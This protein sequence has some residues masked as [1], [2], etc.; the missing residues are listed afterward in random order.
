MKYNI[1]QKLVSIYMN[2]TK[3]DL[4]LSLSHAYQDLKLS[5]NIDDG[6]TLHLSCFRSGFGSFVKVSISEKGSDEH[7]P[8][9]EEEYNISTNLKFSDL[10]N[11]AADEWEKYVMITLFKK[12]V[13]RFKDT[14]DRDD[15]DMLF[16]RHRFEVRLAS[17]PMGPAPV[18]HK[19]RFWE[20][21]ELDR[22]YE[23]FLA[24]PSDVLAW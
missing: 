2:A 15:N 22:S 18:A 24:F 20:L 8:L 12:G 5:F 3:F 17:F 1:F 11:R 9:F 21:L 14:V 4:N 7:I 16:L 23:E 6:S 13:I 10:F 19:S